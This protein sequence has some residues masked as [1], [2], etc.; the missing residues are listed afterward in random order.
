MPEPEPVPLTQ[1]EPTPLTNGVKVV[2]EAVFLPG[3]SL[4]MDGEIK[5]GAMHV[6]AG[7]AA[8]VLLGPLGWGMIAANSYS[9]SVS[10]KHLHEHFFPEKEESLAPVSARSP[11][12]EAA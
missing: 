2:A 4:P 1:A 11:A 9:N 7:L 6:V 12:A 8:R 10:G 3:S 5:T